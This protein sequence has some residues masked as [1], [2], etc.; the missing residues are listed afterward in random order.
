MPP[1]SILK[2]WATSTKRLFSIAYRSSTIAIFSM[3]TAKSARS[4]T[5]DRPIRSLNNIR[6][7]GRR[8]SAKH[9]R[10]AT[11]KRGT[12]I[13]ISTPALP[14]SWRSHSWDQ[15]RSRNLLPSLKHSIW[16][17]ETPDSQRN[18]QDVYLNRV[19]KELVSKIVSRMLSQASH[20]TSKWWAF[21]PTW[22]LAIGLYHHVWCHLWIRLGTAP[23]HIQANRHPSRLWDLA[24]LL[25][26]KTDEKISRSAWNSTTRHLEGQRSKSGILTQAISPGISSRSTRLGLRTG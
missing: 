8:I 9:H 12:K 10:Y 3:K 15:S 21:C 7:H 20:W 23:F 1:R 5:S 13:S 4:G 6:R 19:C 17:P 26:M 16:L 22:T 2:W 25:L 18:N 14:W 24:Q 11:R